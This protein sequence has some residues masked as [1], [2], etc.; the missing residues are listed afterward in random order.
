M[1]KFIWVRD[2]D[3]VEHFINV[4][5]IVRLTRVPVSGTFSERA[6]IMLNENSKFGDGTISL[7][8][9]ESDTYKDIF[10]KIQGAING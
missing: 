6:Y 1:S 10:A 4:D 7:S 9:D 3:K 8:I 2:R 5:H